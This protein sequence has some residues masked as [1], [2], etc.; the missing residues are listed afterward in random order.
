MLNVW[1]QIM[2]CAAAEPPV[3]FGMQYVVMQYE[4]TLG[5]NMVWQVMLSALSKV[6]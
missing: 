6:V 5:Y 3:N 2:I 4:L 1:Q